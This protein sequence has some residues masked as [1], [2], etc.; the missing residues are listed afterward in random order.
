MCA[1]NSVFHIQLQASFF[2]FRMH[3]D[4]GVKPWNIIHSYIFSAPCIHADH[5]Y[6]FG[7][8]PPFDLWSGGRK[9]ELCNSDSWNLTGLVSINRPPAVFIG[10]CCRIFP[11]DLFSLITFNRKLF[12]WISVL[13]NT[14]ENHLSWYI[15]S[16]CNVI[17][18]EPLVVIAVVWMLRSPS[19]DN[20]SE[21]VEEWSYSYLK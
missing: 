11:F 16:R 4:A 7:L 21:G 9:K 10:W 19:E 2:F 14:E 8:K 13:G 15:Y 12:G 17:P 1:G 20:I 18:N 3:L 6:F 5:Y